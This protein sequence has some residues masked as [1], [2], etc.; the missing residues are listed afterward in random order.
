MDVVWVKRGVEYNNYS[1][2]TFDSSYV[3][4]VIMGLILARRTDDRH[5]FETKPNVF[6]LQ[7]SER[8][9]FHEPMLSPFISKNERRGK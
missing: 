2:L 8:A 5:G 7:Y 6:R 9:T 3:V 4:R 1:F